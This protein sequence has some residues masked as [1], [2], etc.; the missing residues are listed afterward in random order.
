MSQ[1]NKKKLV[2]FLCKNN[3]AR[4]QM[5]EGLMKHYYE[6]YYDVYSAGA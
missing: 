5:A 2:L 1:V 3:S 6:E 4:S